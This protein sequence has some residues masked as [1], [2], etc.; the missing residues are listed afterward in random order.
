MEHVRD[1]LAVDDGGCVG[2]VF[3]Q[4]KPGVSAV[5]AVLAV[6]AVIAMLAEL[7]AM[8]AHPVYIQCR[9]LTAILAA[10]SDGVEERGENASAEELHVRVPETERRCYDHPAPAEREI[11][12]GVEVGEDCV[13]VGCVG[14]AV[15]AGVEFAAPR[16][17]LRGARERVGGME[18]RELRGLGEATFLSIRSILSINPARTPHPLEH[19]NLT[20]IAVIDAWIGTGWIEVLRDRLADAIHGDIITEQTGVMRAPLCVLPHAQLE[21]MIRMTEKPVG[22]SGRVHDACRGGEAWVEVVVGGCSDE[23]GWAVCA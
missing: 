2:A 14:C 10:V 12:E 21:F 6:L 13:C 7:A 19:G 15:C 17:M 11:E 5:L 20:R 18:G 1:A 8:F 3:R 9:H 4:D 16:Q 23:K 22:A